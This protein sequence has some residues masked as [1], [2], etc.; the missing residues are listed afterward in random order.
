MRGQAS[1][2]M[3]FVHLHTHSMYSLLDGA[4]RITDLVSKAAE[5]KMPALALT[6]H[7][8]IY[9][10]VD[11]F[12][13][14]KKAGV[15]PII[16][17]EVYFTPGSIS[18]REGKPELYHLL[19]LAKNDIGL[20][21][22]K[23][24]LSAAAVEG[25]FYKPR[26]DMELLTQHSEGLIGTS[27]CMSGIVSKSIELGMVEQ[28]REWAIKYSQIFAPGDFYLEIQD[29][30]IVADNG[31]TQRQLCEKI[32]A[33]GEELGLPLVATNDIHYISQEDSTTQDLLLC[34]GTGTTLSDEKR[35][36][37]SSTEFYMKSP[38]EMAEVMSAYP[39][40]LANT[41][42]IAEKCSVDIDFDSLHLPVFPV[43]EGMTQ[44]GYLHEQC[45]K[46]LKVRYGDPVPDSVMARLDSEIAVINEHGF[47]PYF[48]V[49]ADIVQWAKGQGIGVG[50]GRGSAAGSIIAYSLGIT[51]LDP[52]ANGLLFERFLNPERSEMP[53]IDI[54]FDDERRGDVIQYMID[55]YG[56]DKVAQI[57]TFGTMKAR[58]AVRD[59]GRVLGY[60]YGVPDRISKMIVEDLKGTIDSSLAQNSEFKADYDTNI[61]TKKIVDAAR[62][63]EGIV[64]GEGVHAAGVVICPDPVR[65][66]VPVKYDTKGGAV[67]TQWDGVTVG[68][69]GLLK[70]DILG[71]RTLTAIAHAVRGIEERHGLRIDPEQIPIDDKKTFDL[72]SRGDTMGVFQV[73]SAGMRQ[74]LK[75]M[76]P[77]TFEDV[78]A[79]L[80]L[81]RPGPLGS[82]MVDDFVE[83]KLGRKEVTYYDDRLAPILKET[84]GTVVYQEQVM[85]IS[86]EMSGFS[87]AKADKLRKAMGKKLTDVLAALKGDWVEGAKGNGYDAKL[88]ESMWNDIEPFAEYAFNKSH[89]AAYGLITLQTAYLKAHYP[90]EYMAA[91]LSSH[92]GKTE[93]IVKYVAECNRAGL[94]ILPPDVNSSNKRFT[95]V[96]E[97]IRFGLADI[98]G[99]GEAVVEE[100]LKA[101][102]K[103]GPFS[104]LHD[105]CERVE[106]GKFNKKT[107]EALVKAGA[108]DSTGYSRMQL[109][110]LVDEC[111]ELAARRHK[112]R[113]SGQVSM[114]DLFSAE[115]V[116]GID[117][118]PE[119]SGE[120]WDKKIKLTFEKEMLGIYVSDHPLKAIAGKIREAADYSLLEVEDLPAGTIARFAGILSAVDRK[121]TRAGKMMAIMTLEDL[122][123]S[124]EAVLFPQMFDKFRDLIAEEAQVCL[125]A[126]IEE[127]DRG[128]KLIVMDV[129]ALEPT[130]R[131][132][133][134]G[135]V[136]V[137]TDHAAIANGR[138]DELK[139]LVDR[140]PG[141]D[142]LE[143][144]LRGSGSVRVFACGMV[145]RYENGLHAGLMEMFGGACVRT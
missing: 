90:S 22:L 31:V 52:I 115:D 53:D 62:A 49:V 138:F 95:A 60:P 76:K 128:R 112:D 37:F 131:V 91:V 36:K 97:G 33:L 61:D 139:E 17:C 122:G 30:G 136:V 1:A 35:M 143:L 16:G 68:D 58:A 132:R 15:K 28:A 121:P 39:Q 80:A 32:A 100:I 126:K 92:Q 125:K 63:L 79:I 78:V 93:N 141:S 124:V 66:H 14:A 82:G 119:P 110:G 18:Q 34:I 56:E 83:R 43:P 89:S 10:A 20:A 29:Q 145:D 7:G 40:A 4:A 47:A 44:E 120:E 11:F 134:P 54:D 65:T 77:T 9:G 24:L 96:D 55:E 42:E 105:F 127:D 38:A 6:D 50:P 113:Q 108:F 111:V 73:E 5:H 144:H 129:T 72:L 137:E 140:Y 123:G 142:T 70:M 57:I 41:L 99:V 23:S 26:I 75:K 88:A 98:R 106:A 104:S 117:D 27:A 114:F 46:G 25:F 48:L 130:E 81:Y 67:I 103:G 19:L 2:D 101:R 8:Y 13:Q 45:V 3:S 86:M 94:K 84:Y 118:I 135:K 133:K 107:L 71:L 109:S 59:A 87:A 12:R 21:N 85:R 69:L 116:G 51:T 64:R 102:E 74:L